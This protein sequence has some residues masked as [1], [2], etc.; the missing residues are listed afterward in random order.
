MP[1]SEMD[2]M[3]ACGLAFAT[4]TCLSAENYIPDKFEPDFWKRYI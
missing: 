2:R 4:E 3:V 1:D